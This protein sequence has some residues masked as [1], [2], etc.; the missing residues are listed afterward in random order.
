[1]RRWLVA[2]GLIEGPEG[3]LLV[4]NRR[5]NGSFDWSTPGGVIDPGETV[6]EGLSREVEEETGLA[7]SGWE[8]P[9]YHVTA[10]APG[11]GWHLSVE[12][13]QAVSFDGDVVVD[14]P[15]GIVVDACFVDAQ[16]CA[17][18]LAGTQAW[19]REPLVEYLSERWT[20]TRSFHYE[21]DGSDRDSIVV[22]RS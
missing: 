19:V 11:L 5:R 4:Q 12:V 14:D 1:M 6:L 16:A 21:V 20:G 7:V 3:V 18:H 13:H 10:A 8:G 2:G 9:V 17:A 15:D 22:R